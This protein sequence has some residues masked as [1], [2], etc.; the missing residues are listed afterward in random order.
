MKTTLLLAAAGALVAMA[1]PAFAEQYTDYTPQKGAWEVTMVKVDPAHIDDYLTGLKGSW[2]PSMKISKAH[3]TID[4]YEVMVKLNAS[5]GNAN[6]MLAVHYPTLA[7]LDPD[8]ARDQTIEKENY[9][10]MSK[11]KSE[12]VVAGYGKYRT[13]VGDDI[14]VPVDFDAK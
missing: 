10:F 9:A 6:V 11:D 4:R 1:A 7:V 5:D 8:K 12:A 14:Y 13:F 2:V 3:G